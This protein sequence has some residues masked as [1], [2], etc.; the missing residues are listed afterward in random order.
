MGT[1][2]TAGIDE[3]EEACSAEC[4]E[5]P[6]P[7]VTECPPDGQDPKAEEHCA[8]LQ[9]TSGPFAVRCEYLL[10]QWIWVLSEVVSCRIAWLKWT[11]SLLKS[12]SSTASMIPAI[13]RTMRMLSVT[14]PLPWLPSAKLCSRS[15]CHGEVMICAVSNF[16]G[17]IIR[18]DR[19]IYLSLPPS[20]SFVTFHENAFLQSCSSWL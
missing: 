16:P 5:P 4:P 15:L 6:E 19:T 17:S 13:W 7:P 8:A 1:S 11:V 10:S 9:D 18:S 2:W 3:N 14:M 12:F 20:H